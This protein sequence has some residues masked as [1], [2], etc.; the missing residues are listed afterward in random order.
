VAWNLYGPG[1]DEIL[2]RFQY[3]TGGYIHYHLDAMGNVQFLLGEG[4]LG[5]EKY[6]YDAFGQPTIKDWNGNYLKISG[7]GNRFMFTGREY[8]YTLGLYDYR[9]R[10]Y[11][12]SL[13]R[14]IQTDPIG[15]Q[16]EGAKLSAQQ[17]AFYAGGQAPAT[18]NASELNLY[19]YCYNDPINKSDPTGLYWTA[20]KSIYKQVEAAW[21]YLSKDPGMK[22]AID[23]IAK[24]PTEVYVRENKTLDPNKTVTERV[25]NNRTGDV[26]YRIN[27]NPQ[28]AST[29]K[30]GTQ[31]PAMVLGH[32]GQH[33]VRDIRDWRGAQLD[34]ARGAPGFKNVEERRV[35]LG[36]ETDA[37][38]NL[39]EGVRNDGRAAF[40]PVNGVTDR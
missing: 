35:I 9:H 15:L 28:A 33:A 23:A 32:E 40:F 22:A 20:D 36:P 7:Y 3:S 26:S 37:A 11:H 16:I 38:R 39:Q 30:G 31:S 1:A 19:G 14:F 12:P 24:S 25:T 5:L 34:L 29:F 18:F 4:N 13:G 27:W 17:T 2:V 10:L 6:T 21:E 8:L